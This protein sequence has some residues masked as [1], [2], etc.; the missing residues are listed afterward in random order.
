MLKIK[1]RF[2]KVQD[3]YKGGIKNIIVKMTTIK[4]ILEE[5]LEDL[6]PQGHLEE[7]VQKFPNDGRIFVVHGHDDSMKQSIARFLEKLDLTPIILHEQPDQGKTLIE[8]LEKHSSSVDFAV[9]LLTPDDKGCPANEPENVRE[10]ARQNV[11]LELGLFIGLIGRNRVCA[12]YKGNLEI[13]TDYAGVAYIPIDEN[14]GWKLRLAKEIKQVLK[15]DLNKV[16]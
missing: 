12:L 15:I 14:D 8:K 13:P 5:K 9:I 1:R 2:Y 4:E 16:I 3:S 6:G 10:R 7:K 11:I